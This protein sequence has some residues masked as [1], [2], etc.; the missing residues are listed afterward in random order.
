MLSFSKEKKLV[1]YI[2]S[3]EIIEGEEFVT[4]LNLPTKSLMPVGVLDKVLVKHAKEILCKQCHQQ[5]TN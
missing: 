1:C 4:R 2:C 5:S 3:K